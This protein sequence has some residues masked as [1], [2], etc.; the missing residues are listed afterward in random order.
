MVPLVKVTQ[1]VLLFFC[2]L[3]MLAS[4]KQNSLYDTIKMWQSMPCEEKSEGVLHGRKDF[5][6]FR[7]GSNH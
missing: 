1:A 7:Q 3:Q 2:E 4:C 6:D 5:Q